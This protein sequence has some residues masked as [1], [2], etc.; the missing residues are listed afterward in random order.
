MDNLFNSKAYRELVVKNNY[1]TVEFL[2]KEGVDFAIVA[3][4]DFIEFNPE[5]PTSIIEFD[6]Y[7]LFILAGYSKESALLNEK[8][9]SFEAGFGENNFGSTLTISLDAVAQIL[10]GEDVIN[11]SHYEPEEESTPQE[12]Q[13]SMELL[14]NNPENQNLLK[15]VKNKNKD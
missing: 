9:F 5:I 6:E 12:T 13:N 15:R 10:V 7:A 3:F 11:V 2:L 8:E 1:N 4:S 14:L